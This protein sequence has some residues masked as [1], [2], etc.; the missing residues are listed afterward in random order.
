MLRAIAQKPQMPILNPTELYGTITFLGVVPDRAASLR[1]ESRKTLTLHFEGV[2]GES[3]SGITRPS[4]VRVTS[5]Y[6]KGTEIRNVRQLSILSAEELALMAADMGMD[7]LPPEYLGAT[8]VLSGI[9]DLT[10]LPPNSRLISENGTSITVDME[11]GP[12]Q[13]PACEIEM[14]F[15]GKGQGFMPAAR[16]RRGVMAWVER[17]GSLTIGDKMRLHVPPQRVYLPL[18]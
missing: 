12:C 16:N 17:P 7:R 18:A 1:A 14:D 3:H 6:P 9:P 10:L 2:V 5:Q 15:P 13:F 8:L 11:N 4:C